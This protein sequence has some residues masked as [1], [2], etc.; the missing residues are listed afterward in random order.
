MDEPAFDLYALIEDPV[1][2]EFYRY[3]SEMHREQSESPLTVPHVASR[4]MSDSRLGTITGVVDTQE[5]VG[6]MF[7]QLKAAGLLQIL[8][9]KYQAPGGDY[10]P[11]WQ[12]VDPMDP[13]ELDA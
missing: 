5:E 4:L 11:Q 1:L 8:D 7:K 6:A 13:F 12:L 3:L 10:F 9:A 2:D